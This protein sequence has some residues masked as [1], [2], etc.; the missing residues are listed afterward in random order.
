MNAIHML[1]AYPLLTHIQFLELHVYVWY[2]E[3]PKEFGE[4]LRPLL[5]EVFP[6]Q[7]HED[8]RVFS[9]VMLLREDQRSVLSEQLEVNLMDLLSLLRCCEHLAIEVVDYIDDRLKKPEP[10]SLVL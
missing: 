7:Q 3:K 4:G 10:G 6:Q 5:R 1:N 9:H 8:Q 2:F